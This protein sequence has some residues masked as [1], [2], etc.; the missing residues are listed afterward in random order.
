[1]ALLN[2]KTYDSWLDY[3]TDK[4]AGDRFNITVKEIP[5]E[6]TDTITVT[7]KDGSSRISL[8]FDIIA[9][10]L[11]RESFYHP[12]TVL[13]NAE[14]DRERKR[15]LML[16]DYELSDENLSAMDQYLDIPLRYGYT[17]RTVY[18]NGEFRRFELLYK[19]Q[20]HRVYDNTSAGGCLLSIFTW[21]FR[22]FKKAHKEEIKDIS[23]PPMI[24]R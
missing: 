21:P 4:F 2:N 18:A 15:S 6:K 14:N 9:H 3:I 11:C 22:S 17:E 19:G 8:V 5:E 12:D 24:T 13:Y 20:I 16:A 1:M 23:I 10:N 7:L